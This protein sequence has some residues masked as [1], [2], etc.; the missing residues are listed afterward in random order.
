MHPASYKLRFVYEEL[1]VEL[2]N[3]WHISNVPTSG[4]SGN[5]RYNRLLWTAKEFHKKH[6]EFSETAI[7]KDLDGMVP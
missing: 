6:P 5:R 3:L 4:V 2:S 1:A 7:Y